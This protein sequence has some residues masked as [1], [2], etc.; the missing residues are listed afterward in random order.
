MT[1]DLLRQLGVFAVLCLA[2]AFV[3]NRIHLFGCATPLIYIYMIIK[4]ERNY[5]KWGILLWSFAL[6]VT[7]DALSNTP[8]VAAA[9]LTLIGAVQ[10]YFMELFVQRDAAENLSPSLKTLGYGK[11]TFFASMLTLLYCIVFFTLET[12]SFFN[13]SQWIAQVLGSAIISLVIILTIESVRK[14]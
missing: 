1:I 7:V 2:Q 13:L 11:F 10:P 6:G 8:G 4:L 5:P 12:F 14:Q 3:F 9:S